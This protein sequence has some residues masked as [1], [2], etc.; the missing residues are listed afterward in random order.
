MPI[1]SYWYEVTALSGT[2]KGG[3]ATSNNVVFGTH[4]EVPYFEDF[5]TDGFLHLFTTIDV[6]DDARNAVLFR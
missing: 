3:A 2:Q 6:E 5:A 4:Y 1:K